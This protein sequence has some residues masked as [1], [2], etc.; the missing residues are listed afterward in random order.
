MTPCDFFKMHRLKQVD[1]MHTQLAGRGGPL[2]VPGSGAPT[3]CGSVAEYG[4]KLVLPWVYGTPVR[5]GSAVLRVPDIVAVMVMVHGR[6]ALARR[7]V[8]GRS[9]MFLS[10]QN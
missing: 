9:P 4:C 7:D 8:T 3:E 10:K 1:R 6:C 2:G 5:T